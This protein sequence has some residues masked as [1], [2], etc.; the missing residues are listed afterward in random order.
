MTNGVSRP[1]AREGSADSYGKASMDMD[2]D[3]SGDGAGAPSTQQSTRMPL[4]VPGTRSSHEP[5]DHVAKSF[6][7]S[8][9]PMGSAEHSA[10]GAAA[11]DGG[12]SG[13]PPPVGRARAVDEPDEPLRGGEYVAKARSFGRFRLAQGFDEVVGVSK[14]I[15]NVNVR[16]PEAQAWFRVHPDERYRL[17]V[18]LLSLKEENETFIVDPSLIG[19]LA[20][21]VVPHVL[22]TY[23][24]RQNVV[25]IWPVR[26]PRADGRTDGWMRSSHEAAELA[27]KCWVRLQSNRSAGA[28]DVN[29]TSAKLP[30]PEWPTMS[31]EQL[32]EKAFT[33]HVIDTLEHPVLR[34]LRG[35]I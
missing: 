26:L 8:A 16:K 15:A 14:V 31:F 13:T 7:T 34:R 24:T 17:P 33:D 23:V 18:A 12:G 19:S 30:E 35:E 10:S 5:T 2:A 9:K 28:Y 29:V 20:A 3:V 4:P 32:L 11:P 22:Y 27:M 21:E 25:G 6:T 1:W